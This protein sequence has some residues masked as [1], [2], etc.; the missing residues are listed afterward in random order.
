[1]NYSY[2]I[3]LKCTLTLS[4]ATDLVWKNVLGDAEKQWVSCIQN[5][6]ISINNIY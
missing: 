1:M 2:M 4:H 6:D 5:H 3:I